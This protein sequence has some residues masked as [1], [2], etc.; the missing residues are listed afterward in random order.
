MAPPPATTTLLAGRPMPMPTD[1]SRDVWQ[2]LRTSNLVMTGSSL[3]TLRARVTSIGNWGIIAME[4]SGL[5]N[6]VGT[7][8]VLPRSDYTIVTLTASGRYH[9]HHPTFLSQPHAVSAHRLG[10]ING[11]A[12]TATSWGSFSQIAFLIPTDDLTPMGSPSP[13]GH[14]VSAEVA[15]GRILQSCL[16]AV[17]DQA[18]QVEKSAVLGRLLPATARFIAA[19]LAEGVPLEEGRRH[20]DPLDRLLD[21]IAQNLDNPV[22]SPAS[23]AARC[24]VSERTL[25]RLFAKAGKRFQTVVRDMRLER[26]GRL[27]DDDPDKSIADVA[28]ESGFSSAT[29]FG[30]VFRHLHDMTP[31]HYRSRG[32]TA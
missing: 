31:R 17:A 27:L 25:Y 8:G 7:P 10:D 5:L 13:Y 14:V 4:G 16:R 9:S 26:A 30:R 6:V 3:S 15:S 12:R 2:Y 24:G 21:L 23:L 32:R 22:L 19:A 11:L 18:F 20:P 1:G 28:H 29:Q